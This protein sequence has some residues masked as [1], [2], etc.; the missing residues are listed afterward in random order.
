MFTG[1]IQHVGRLTALEPRDWGRRLIIDAS[2][3][4][5]T[6]GHGDSIAVDGCCLTVADDAPD[7]AALAFDVV[8]ES[9]NLTRLGTTK[10]GGR[11]NLEHSVRADTLMDGHIVQGHVDGLGRVRT[12]QDNAADWRVT[13]EPPIHLMECI[14]PKGSVTVNGVSLTIA[15]VHQD[16][17]EVALIPTTLELTNLGDLTAGDPV[18]V[19]TDI[20]ARTVVHWLKRERG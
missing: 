5:H 1:I 19:E 3:W 6:P 10:V 20:V 9:L 12:I 15:T 4:S 11:V 16:A 8:T 18:N 13:I 14:A 17:F 2:G 7:P